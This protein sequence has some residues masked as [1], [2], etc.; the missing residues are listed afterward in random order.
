MYQYGWSKRQHGLFAGRP[1]RQLLALVPM[2][3]RGSS[4]LSPT[5]LAVCTNNTRQISN[6]IGSSEQN[7]R[8]VSNT[9]YNF[10]QEPNCKYFHRKRQ[11]QF[12]LLVKIMFTTFVIIERRN[13]LTYVLITGLYRVRIRLTQKHETVAVLHAIVIACNIANYF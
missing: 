6:N 11:S 1:G 5:L 4:V 9:L 7:W 8:T 13:T 3:V 10:S 2:G 12:D